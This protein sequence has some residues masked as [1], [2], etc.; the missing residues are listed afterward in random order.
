[1]EE[2]LARLREGG[3]LGEKTTQEEDGEQ[4]LVSNVSK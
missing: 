2:E 4:V 1:M 3:Q